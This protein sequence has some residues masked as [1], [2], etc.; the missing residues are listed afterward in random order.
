MT[1][2]DCRGKLHQ[3]DYRG[4]QIDECASSKG[5]W[6]DRDEL[7]KAKDKTDDDLR[8]LDFDAFGDH[9]DKLKVSSTRRKQC[10]RC[11][12]DMS[13]LTYDTSQV[14]IDKCSQC[15][16]IWLN[17][18]EFEAIVKYLE[19]IVMTKTASEYAKDV[20]KQFLEIATGPESKLSEV[21]DFLA[22]LKLLELRLVVENP[23]IIEASQKI[24]RYSPF[25]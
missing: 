12:V 14:R 19:N 22:V 18:G 9:V 23:K 21:R 10:P 24:Y 13:A 6:F 15:K 5:R 1:C 11:S 17:H 20:F 4:I 25:K 2:P 7:R 3:I 16:G 8:W